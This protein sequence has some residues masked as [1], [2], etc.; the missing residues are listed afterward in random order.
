LLKVASFA[1]PI[2]L[3]ASPLS[4]AEPPAASEGRPNMLALT[5]G[6]VMV[7]I[8][9][10]FR[11]GVGA[12]FDGHPASGYKH[13]DGHPYPL[14][15]VL[16]LGQLTRL[17]AAAFDSSQANEAKYPGI[18]ARTVELW[19]S[20]KGPKE[21]FEKVATFELL[22][23]G[24]TAQPLPKPVEA[25]WVKLVV[26]ANHGHARFS[27]LNEAELFGEWV[28]KVETADFSGD[29][30]ANWGPLRV[31]QRGEEVAGCGP[32]L[33]FRGT[34]LGRAL[35]ATWVST[36]PKDKSRGPLS[37]VMVA[38]GK[39]RGE[40]RRDGAYP[41]DSAG[42]SAERPRKPVKIDCTVDLPGSMAEE[43]AAKG[44]IA[45]YGI[46]F[47]TDSDVPLPESDPTLK[48]VLGALQAKPA[49]RLAVEGHTDSTS[50]DAH[51]L[52]LSERRAKSVVQ[53]LVEHGIDVKRLAPKGYGEGKPVASNDTSDGRALNRR[54][55]VAVLP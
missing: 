40:G 46:R 28:G 17:D 11:G 10:Q 37:L 38:P 2:L 32:A 22:K 44:R 24:R 53:W 12:L 41:G 55:E 3:A 15:L 36:K 13:Y 25:R 51:N 9:R 5:E 54:V 16:E 45:L 30:A 19:V 50:S 14:T 23:H 21:G 29:W 47:A 8:D 4:G 27:T 20:T 6:A 49:L 18:S 33:T 52:D 31:A 39:I 35:R 26:T 42:W 34:V 43:L 1:I 7:E 48:E